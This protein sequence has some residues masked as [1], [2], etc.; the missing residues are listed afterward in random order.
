MPATP[1][2]ALASLLI[3]RGRVRLRGFRFNE[4]HASELDPAQLDRMRVCWTAALGLPTIDTITAA[5]FQ[6]RHLLMA[7]EEFLVQPKS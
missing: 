7:L 2:R 6:A 5:D 4:S 3:N 1:R